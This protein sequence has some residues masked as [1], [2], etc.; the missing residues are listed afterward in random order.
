MGIVGRLPEAPHT[1]AR[2]LI[3]KAKNIKFTYLFSGKWEKI[4]NEAT[5]VRFDGTYGFLTK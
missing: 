2:I 5:F 1:T 3:C 4:S